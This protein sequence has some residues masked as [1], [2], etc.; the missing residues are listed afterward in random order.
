MRPKYFA[1][2]GLAQVTQCKQTKISIVRRMV[3]LML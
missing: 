1:V 3:I 2:L